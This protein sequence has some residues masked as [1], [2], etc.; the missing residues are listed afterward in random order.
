MAFRNRLDHLADCNW[1]A[2]QYPGGGIGFRLITAIWGGLTFS[3]TES[4]GEYGVGGW[5]M[6]QAH[7]KSAPPAEDVASMPDLPFWNST[8][9]DDGVVVD[10]M[11]VGNRAHYSRSSYLEAMRQLFSEF[12]PSMDKIATE[13]TFAAA[14]VLW[15]FWADF[16][17][18]VLSLPETKLLRAIALLSLAVHAAGQRRVPFRQ[19]LALASYSQYIGVVIPVVLPYVSS[20][21]AMC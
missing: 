12:A 21:W 17:R 13:G 14:M 5:A 3:W 6:P 20:L 18:E 7:C 16:D 1:F 10:L 19:H 15:V 9:V 11:S 8:F 4:P 2:T